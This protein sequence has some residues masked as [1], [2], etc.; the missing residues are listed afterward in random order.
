M[1]RAPSGPMLSTMCPSPV[2]AA[3]L[4]SSCSFPTAQTLTAAKLSSPRERNQKQKKA[5]V[6]ATKNPRMESLI[7]E[8]EVKMTKKAAKVTRTT[9]AVKAAV[10]PEAKNPVAAKR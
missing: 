1:G 9:R 2:K 7:T 6:M 10:N 3:S 4:A 8:V 5:A